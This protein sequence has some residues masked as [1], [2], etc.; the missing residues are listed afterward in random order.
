VNALKE[1]SK[2]KN[3]GE[4]KPDPDKARKELKESFKRLHPEWTDVQAEDA[5]KGR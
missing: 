4:T 5:V 1:A 3:L 2:P